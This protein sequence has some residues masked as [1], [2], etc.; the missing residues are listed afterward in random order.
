MIRHLILDFDGTLGDTTTLIL[1]TMS[2]TFRR[3]GLPQVSVEKCKASIGLR[4]YETPAFLFPDRKDLDADEFVRVWRKVQV[5]LRTKVGVKLYPGVLS[6]LDLL[7]ERG[8]DMAVA[9]SR[10]GESLNGYLDSLGLMPYMSTVV[11][12]D[13]VE[14]G[15]P[16]PDAALKVMD[17]L[18]WQPSES[19][20]VGD[21]SVDIEMGHAA[22]TH[23]CAVTYGNGTLA[24]L[25]NSSPD[26]IIDSFPRLAD[27]LSNPAF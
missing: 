15:K 7:K 8:I 24:D 23:T 26:A 6:T 19:M 16:Y 27:V 2:E 10:S 20:T 1:A 9:S 12:A 4:P 14:H 13:D 17:R 3:L 18:G 25:Q 21:A 22:G 11:S 5:E